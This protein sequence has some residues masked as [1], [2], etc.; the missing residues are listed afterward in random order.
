[1]SALRPGIRC[2][3]Q[4]NAPA[5]RAAYPSRSASD[6]YVVLGQKKPRSPSPFRRGTTCTCR[7]GTL[8]EILLFSA[9]KVP[10]AC[11]PVSTARGSRCTAVQNGPTLPAGRRV[12]VLDVSGGH[13]QH[14]SLEHRAGIEERAHFLT[15]KHERGSDLPRRMA[16]K[17]QGRAIAATMARGGRLARWSRPKVSGTRQFCVAFPCRAPGCVQRERKSGPSPA[18]EKKDMKKLIA[19]PL[20]A[21]V[22]CGGGAFKDQARD[23][24]PSKESVSMGAPS[25]SGTA[26]SST[27]LVSSDSVAGQDSPFRGL[28]VV[29]AVV[30]NV[31]TAAF[32]DLLTHVVEDNEPTSCDASS[33]T[34]GPGSGPLETVDYKLVVS[35]DADGTSFDWQLSG[36][37]KPGTTFV[38]FASGVATPGPQRHH[39]SGSFQIDFDKMAA[40]G[41]AGDA[42]GLMNV[43]SYSNVGPAQLAVT[44]TGAKDTGS[45]GHEE[46]PRLQPTPTTTPAAATSTSPCT[47]PPREDSFSVHSRWKNDGRGRADV[48]GLGAGTTSRSP[49]A[50]APLPSR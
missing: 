8:C 6:S 34:W 31:P 35:R 37:V 10:C 20:V 22:A 18:K 30:F 50:G 43:T 28:T 26:S 4:P 49:S 1:M 16:Q 13:D 14:V 11:R 29:V 12:E 21:A 7:W 40:L 42:T 24:M 46:Q 23:A 48:A 32:L 19:L 41:I 2:M 44:F 45:S 36:A 39:G 38:T 27:A 9:M 47:T 33:C 3:P 15:P 17:T 5:M 25:S